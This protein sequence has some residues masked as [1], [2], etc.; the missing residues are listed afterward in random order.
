MNAQQVNITTND[1]ARQASYFAPSSVINNGNDL[2]NKILG[3]FNIIIYV[4][5]ALAVVYIVY[6][7]VMYMIKGNEPEGKREAAKSF[8]WGVVGL[9]LIV[10]LWGIVNIL[11]NTFATN[12]SNVPK[13]P[14][15]NFVNPSN[16]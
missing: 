11:T 14:N 12:T 13:L 10:S 4:L 6:N 8:G 3:V 5:V 2:V 15:A 16:F 1:A 9:S 7:V